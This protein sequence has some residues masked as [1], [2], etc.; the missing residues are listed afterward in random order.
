MPE[1]NK[2]LRDTQKSKKEEPEKKVSTELWHG[3]LRQGLYNIIIMINI[4]KQVRVQK[5]S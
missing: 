1:F 2:I 5:E 4:H 3:A